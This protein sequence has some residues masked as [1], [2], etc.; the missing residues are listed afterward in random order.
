MKGILL[1]KVLVDGK[2]CHGGDGEYPPPGKWTP[3]REPHICE[4]GYHLTSDPL[5]W[6]IPKA[7]LWLAE[8][9][10]PLNGD[11][12][13]KAA[14]ERVRLV[15]Q[16]TKDWPLLVMFPRLRAFLAASARSKEKDAS[17][18]WANL[19]WANL[20][21]AN[22]SGANLYGAIATEAPA[23]WKLENGILIKA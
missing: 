20:S 13:D 15:E 8:G 16:I 3:K 21:G 4:S 2:P 9:D 11:G 12:S 17:I 14:F 19:S 5:R 10:G 23:G 7:E 6:W 22:L 1:F 18:K